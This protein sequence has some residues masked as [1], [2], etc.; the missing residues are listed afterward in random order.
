MDS[1]GHPVWRQWGA[2]LRRLRELAGVSQT[3]LGRK[4]LAS[5]ATISAWERGTRVP[6]RESSERLD[7][8]L[9]TGGVLTR[10]WHDVASQRGVPDWWRSALALERQSREIW[11]YEPS[12][13][14]GLLQTAD[15]ARYIIESRRPRATKNEVDETVAQR[16]ERLPA[17]L[18]KGTL[19]RLVVGE[20][21]LVRGVRGQRPMMAELDDI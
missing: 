13:V 20:A 2:E 7:T 1:D 14:P 4:T 8:A 18:E 3:D 12:I 16:V 6:K 11:E 5:K 17:L 15:Y 21:P 10:L 19:I 9:S